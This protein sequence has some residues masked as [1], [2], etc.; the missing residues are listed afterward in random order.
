MCPDIKLI[1][2]IKKGSRVTKDTTQIDESE[3][4]KDAFE[5]ARDFFLELAADLIHKPDK[6]DVSFAGNLPRATLPSLA[7]HKETVRE[8]AGTPD[9]TKPA[10]AEETDKMK[11]RMTPARRP[12]KRQ[13][14]M[15]MDRNRPK[16]S[17]KKTSAPLNSAPWD[18]GGF[19]IYCSTKEYQH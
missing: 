5:T 7:S 18:A 15:K 13:N 11:K 3:S 6:L 9:I 17:L 1:I 10:P 4:W 14:P 12:R 8:E 16:N 2:Q 19:V